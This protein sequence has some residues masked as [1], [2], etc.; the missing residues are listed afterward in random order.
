MG[1]LLNVVGLGT[2]IVL[3]ATLLLMVGRGPKTPMV[4]GTGDRLPLATAILGLAWN[5]C[6]LS[7]Y[8]LQQAGIRGPAAYFGVIG[9]SALGFL[10]AVVVHSVLRSSEDSRGPIPKVPLVGVAYA[11]STFAALLHLEAMWRGDP[12]PEAGGM[13][14][15]TYVFVALVVPVALAARRQRGDRRAVWIA[16]LAAFAVSAMH[17]AQLHTGHD[18]WPV[19]LVGH[20][21][22][23]PL[24]L[25]ILYQDY[26][27][28][29]ADI[30]LKRALTLTAVVAVAFVGVVTV[31]LPARDH[32]SAVFIGPRAVGL[33]VILW[34][35]TAL[36]YPWL[37]RSIG[38]FVDAVVLGRPNYRVLRAHVA[39][40]AQEHQQVVPLLDDVC[41]LLTPALSCPAIHWHEVGA[42]TYD[43]AEA[44]SVV[45]MAHASAT[46]VIPTSD[47]PQY[48]IVSGPMTGGRRLLSGDVIMLEA[49][50]TIVARRVDAIRLVTERHEREVR[51]QEI[52]KLATEAELRAL[53][54]QI[55]PHFLFNA[56]T[57]IGYLIQTAPPR[58]LH[59][60]MRLTVLLRSVLRSEGEFTTLEHELDLIEAYLD[61]E[62][63]RFEDRLRVNIDVPSGLRQARV[64]PLLLQPLVENA[65][66][67]G[68]APKRYGGDVTIRAR[69]ERCGGGTHELVLAVHDTGDGVS[70]IAMQRGRERGVGLQNVERRL[71]CQYGA[72]ASLVVRSLPGTGTTAEIRLPVAV[73]IDEQAVAVGA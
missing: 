6:A 48:A 22:S 36:I 70:D 59:T 10:P 50:A 30:F 4:R 34:V 3:Y 29:L 40:R 64:L 42:S 31:G 71:A 55:N 18:P 54:A 53:R 21:A 72:A 24:A 15:L 13:R 63:A 45:Q 51:E 16:A 52:A 23:V 69:L 20:H 56:L 11:A 58:A 41:A 47:R 65:I 33:L 5:V 28:A 2:G 1:E 14:L 46:T 26:P 44:G 37:H 9:L 32:E 35:A 39:R 17:L 38:W 25:A 73:W 12:V 67:H 62:R 27:F 57:T 61:I 49:L 8:E 43:E 68:V 7:A 19:E 66:K 60:L